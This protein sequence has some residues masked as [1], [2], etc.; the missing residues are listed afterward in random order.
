MVYLRFFAI[1]L[2]AATGGPVLADPYFEH[3]L[4]PGE[5]IPNVRAIAC[6]TPAQLDVI[7][8][9]YSVDYQSGK[10]AY[11]ASRRSTEYDLTTGQIASTCDELWF[12]AIVPVRTISWKPY[13]VIFANG[14]VHR[15]Y[16]IEAVPV[17]P[18]GAHAKPSY[19]MSSRWRVGGR[20]YS[21]VI[22]TSGKQG[23]GPCRSRR[24]T[25]GFRSS[26]LGFAPDH[27]PRHGFRLKFASRLANRR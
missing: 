2:L 22:L 7:L 23:R 20:R 25:G 12:F 1:F 14:T 15:R 27:L 11:E 24:S 4:R 5:L 13:H 10:A 21:L 17:G 19:F 6:N 3:R 8:S 16:I 18:D 9:A 26:S